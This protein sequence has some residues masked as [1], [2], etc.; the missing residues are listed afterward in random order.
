MI[1]Q[2]WQQPDLASQVRRYFLSWNCSEIRFENNNRLGDEFNGFV[3]RVLDEIFE[4]EEQACRSKWRIHLQRRCEEAWKGLLLVRL[5]HL[6]TLEIV[7][8]YTEGLVPDILRKAAHRQRPFHEAPPFP[9]LRNIRAS[10]GLMEP[11]IGSRF[12]LPFFYFPAVRI[13]EGVHYR[14]MRYHHTV[15]G[16]EIDATYRKSILETLLLPVNHSSR[17]VRKIVLQT[18]HRNRDILGW[19]KACTQLEH[20]DIL[21]VRSG[22]EWYPDDPYTFS[23]PELRQALLPSQTTLRTLHVG[24]IDMNSAAREMIDSSGPMVSLKEFTVLEDLAIRHAHLLRPS[25]SPSPSS[26]TLGVRDQQQLC[27][28]LPTTIRSLGIRDIV[29]DDFPGLLLELLGLVR[30]QTSSCPPFHQLERI[31]L[32]SYPAITDEYSLNL[33]LHACETAGIVLTVKVTRW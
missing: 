33:L 6:Q 17:P 15:C 30:Q 14:W 23:A 28:I 13:I 8:L 1:I 21:L 29:K 7:S 27:D 31:Q 18:C 10:P 4:P 12:I 22:G 9:C 19:L 11:A 2:I 25:P 24:A 32:Y 20:V 26:A 3:D 5:T 16:L